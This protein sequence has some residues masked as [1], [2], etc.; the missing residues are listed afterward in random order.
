M[1]IVK[2]EDVT[3]AETLEILTKREKEG[4]LVPSQQHCVEFLRKHL[5]FKSK[6]EFEHVKEELKNIKDFKEHQLD[7]LVEVLPVTEDQVYALFSKERIKLSK[8][9][10]KKIIDLCTSVIK[11][12]K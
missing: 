3:A 12:G 4:G 6:K 10:V 9:E 8:E 1:K 5:K 11:N 2:K 7:K